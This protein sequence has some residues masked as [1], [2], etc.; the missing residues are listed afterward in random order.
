MYACVFTHSTTYFNTKTHIHIHI[1]ICTYTHAYTHK[2]NILLTY[3]NL[4][5][6]TSKSTSCMP[7][8]SLCIYRYYLYVSVHIPLYIKNLLQF[9]C[10]PTAPSATKDSTPLPL[11]SLPSLVKPVSSVQRYTILLYTSAHMSRG[12][13]GLGGAFDHP[14]HW[15][16]SIICI[17]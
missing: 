11:P 3:F 16:T 4:L 13:Y 8:S 1:H 14:T 15:D 12:K 10:I 2:I 7:T 17:M 9:T 5:Q 6:S